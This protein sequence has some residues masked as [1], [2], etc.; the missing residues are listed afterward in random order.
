[1]CELAMR[2]DKMRAERRVAD[3]RPNWCAVAGLGFEGVGGGG[4]M[5]GRKNGDPEDHF[6]RIRSWTVH[7]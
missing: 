3:K 5:C 7:R 4:R 1:M 2:D 6:G